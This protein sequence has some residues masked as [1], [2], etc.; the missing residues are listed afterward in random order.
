MCRKNDHEAL[1][2]WIHHLTGSWEIIHAGKPL[3]ELFALLQDS[4]EFSVD[5]FG[6]TVQ[7]V[8]DKGKK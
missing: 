8:L 3:R 7:Q 5:E 4:G 2:E 1:K 6:R